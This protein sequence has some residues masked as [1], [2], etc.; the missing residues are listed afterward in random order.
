VRGSLAG[1][2]VGPTSVRFSGDGVDSEPHAAAM[3]AARATIKPN[4][5]KRRILFL[6]APLHDR[7]STQILERWLPSI[8]REH[9]AR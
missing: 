6:P 9:A 1:I 4:L 5:G 7:P 3:P 2:S 8:L